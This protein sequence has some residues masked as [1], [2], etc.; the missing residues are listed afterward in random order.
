[1]LEYTLQRFP[2]KSIIIAGHSMGGSIAIKTMERIEAMD[3]CQ[4][5]R[6]IKGLLII[7][8]VE[9]TAMEAL[10]FMEQI[11]KNRPQEFPDLRSVVKYGI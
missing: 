10:P 4:I 8:V 11:V 9:G 5:K 6:A 2:N 7:D 1:M 3:D